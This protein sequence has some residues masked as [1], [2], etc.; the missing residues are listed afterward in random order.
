M[1]GSAPLDPVER[2]ARAREQWIAAPRGKRIERER[3][4]KAV[5][6][7]ELRREMEERSKPAE[8]APAIDPDNDRRPWYQK[9]AER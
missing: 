6:A 7:A 3:T 8:P 4:F 9:E 2:I 5:V 1:N